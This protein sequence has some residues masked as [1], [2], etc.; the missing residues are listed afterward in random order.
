MAYI[1]KLTALLFFMVFSIYG[2]SASNVNNE[3]NNRNQNTISIREQEVI[4]DYEKKVSNFEKVTTEELNSISEEKYFVY[5]GRVTCPHC[6]IFVPKLYQASLQIIPITTN[7]NL[8]K[9]IN[10]ENVNDTGLISYREKHGIDY[11]PNFSY[12]Q[13]GI[14]VSSLSIYDEMSVE[15]IANFINKNIKTE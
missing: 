10:S 14:L 6:R 2:C 12:Y 9:Y 11:V 3:N 8:I 7:D 5:T 13:N 4:D 1:S 15:Q